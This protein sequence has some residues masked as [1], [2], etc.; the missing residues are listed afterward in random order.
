MPTRAL[1]DSPAA[2]YNR[3]LACAGPQ[4]IDLLL[5]A[6]T[7]GCHRA[8]FLLALAYHTG[9]DVPVDYTRAA[10]WYEQAASRGDS[11]AMA[12]LGMM[13]LPGQSG[14]VDEIEAYTWIRSA[15]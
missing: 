12:N 6:A 13:R 7:G 2:A 10:S 4:R 3:A 1:Q 14:N 11:F 5:R 15:A 9:Q 8:Q